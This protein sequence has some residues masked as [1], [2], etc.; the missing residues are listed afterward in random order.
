MLFLAIRSSLCF[1]QWIAAENEI[2]VSIFRYE[3]SAGFGIRNARISENKL[4]NFHWLS[5]FTM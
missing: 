4:F 2:A 1:A 3:K 5:L